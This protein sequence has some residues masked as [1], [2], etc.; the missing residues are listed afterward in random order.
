[1]SERKLQRELNKSWIAQRTGHHAE[2]GVVRHATG[3]VRRPELRMVKQVEELG[4]E[5]K[6]KPFIRTEGCLLEDGHIPVVDALHSQRRV[7]SRLGAETPVWRWR[8]T[9]SI[10]PF[11]QAVHRAP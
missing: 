4:A 11:A 9:G 7:N 3:G 6:I 1:M 10:E 2:V 5:F 8:K